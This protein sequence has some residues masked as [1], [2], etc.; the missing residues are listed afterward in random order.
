MFPLPRTRRTYAFVLPNED[1]K[2]CRGFLDRQDPK[3]VASGSSK[4]C[5]GKI[6]YTFRHSGES[7]RPHFLQT[8]C[9]MPCVFLSLDKPGV[10]EGRRKNIASLPSFSST[11]PQSPLGFALDSCSHYNCLQRGRRHNQSQTHSCMYHQ[12]YRST[13]C[14]CKRI[15]RM[16]SRK[17]HKTN[18]CKEEVAYMGLTFVR[19]CAVGVI[20]EFTRAFKAERR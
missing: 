10:R 12:T 18:C 16:S 11:H 15:R 4:A 2:H 20:C 1:H 7:V 9:S 14:Y 5:G 3:P 19:V 6:T 17:S 13:G 8:Y